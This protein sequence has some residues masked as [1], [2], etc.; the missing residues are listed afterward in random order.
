MHLVEKLSTWGDINDVRPHGSPPLYFMVQHAYRWTHTRQRHICKMVTELGITTGALWKRWGSTPFVFEASTTTNYLSWGTRWFRFNGTFGKIYYHSH[1]TFT[2]EYWTVSA[3]GEDLGLT[4]TPYA[5]DDALNPANLTAKGLTIYDA[6]R[7]ILTRIDLLRRNWTSST[8]APRLECRFSPDLW[9]T[10]PSGQ[11]KPRYMA[12]I[13][14]R[15]WSFAEG[16]PMTFMSF[17]RG[18]GTGK[19]RTE[20][21]HTTWYA[22]AVERDGAIPHSAGL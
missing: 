22:L 12:P 3:S 19:Q 21:G 16:D 9:E 17:V 7:H 14:S 18:Q 2:K 1:H 6:M 4:K 11:R 5:Q 20:F 13:C 8:R 10:I 15:E